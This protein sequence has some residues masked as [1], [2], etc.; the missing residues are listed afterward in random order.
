V[1]NEAPTTDSAVILEP[2]AARPRRNRIL[3]VSVAVLATAAVSGLAMTQG[4]TS[5]SRQ[6]D[7]GGRVAATFTVEN[8]RPGQPAVSLQALRGKPVVVNFWASWCGPCRREM[9]AFEATHESLGDRVTF[10]GIDNKDF[11]DSALEFLNKTGVRYES[12]FDPDGNVAGRYG[13]LG[14]PATFFISPDGRVLESTTGEIHQDDL[15]ATI[16][17]LYGVS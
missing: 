14:L 10:V 4:R 15:K 2:E 8:L 9:P 16:S 13:V 6:V 17:R 5:G 1:T 3:W 11:R 12:G 7:R